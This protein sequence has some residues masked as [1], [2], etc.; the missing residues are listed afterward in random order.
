MYENC[1]INAV[2]L[3]GQTPKG[4]WANELNPEDSVH[5]LIAVHTA[6]G[7]IGYGMFSVR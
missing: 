3:N 7:V 4:G 6:E 2:G 5:S 1:G